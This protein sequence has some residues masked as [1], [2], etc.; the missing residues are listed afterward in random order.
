MWE[1]I[2]GCEIFVYRHTN[3]VWAMAWSPNGTYIVSGNGPIKVWQTNIVREVFTY[4]GHTGTNYSGERS[5]VY[6]VACSSDSSRI[7][8]GSAD[9]TVQVWKIT[10]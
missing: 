4:R 10:S 9:K 8:S 3:M 5:L 1:A 2:T 7:A 6:S